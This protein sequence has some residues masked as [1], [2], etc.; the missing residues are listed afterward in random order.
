MRKFLQEEVN[1]ICDE[2]QGT[3]VLEEVISDYREQGEFGFV[4]NKYSKKEEPVIFAKKVGEK[5][6]ENSRYIESY[7]IAT[8]ET[9]NRPIVFLNLKLNEKEKQLF[10]TKKFEEIAKFVMR[11]DYGFSEINKG[12]IAVVEHT[13]ANPIA[14]IHVGNLRNTIQGDTYARI[15]EATGYQVYR[16]FYINDIGLQIG[17][18]V[19][20]YKI[21]KEKRVFPDVKFDHWIGRVY[22][23]MNCL[24]TIITLKR[25]YATNF[26]LSKFNYKFTKKDIDNAKNYF[27]SNIKRLEK[28]I[29]LLDDKNLKVYKK[30]KRELSREI[31]NFNGYKNDFI[32][33]FEISKDL[34]SR[35][36]RLFNTLYNAVQDLDLLGVTSEYLKNYENDL[37]Q[38]IKNI[39]REVTDW[40]IEA[41]KA[42]V[43]NFNVRFDG[44]DYESDVTW[45]GRLEEILARIKKL[46]NAEIQSDGTVKLKYPKEIVNKMC[47]ELDLDKNNFLPKSGIPDLQL[48]RNDGTALYAMKDMAYS[49]KKFEKYKADVVYN[50]ISSE[51]SLPQLQLILPIYQL[52][53]LKVA[54]NLNHYKYE[55]VELLGKTMSGRRAQ[56]ITADDYFFET[57]VRSKIAKQE[58]DKTSKVVKEEK[59]EDIINAVALAS[60]RFPLIESSPNKKITLDLERELDFRRN[61]GPLILYAY[62]RTSGVLRKTNKKEDLDPSRVKFEYLSN[63]EIVVK[64]M[65]TLEVLTEQ[66]LES[67]ISLD[68]SKLSTWCRTLALDFMKFYETEKILGLSDEEEELAKIMLVILIRKGLKTGLN[69]LGLN[70]VEWL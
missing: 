63:I 69:I 66:V 14:P 28:E 58:S 57:V 41:F 67:Q 36:P 48:I 16:L 20:G 54:K 1:R 25:K 46:D 50:V 39:F 19:V 2:L 62:A 37:N 17:F 61:S 15:L 45:E 53:Y 6:V 5:L 59:D 51:Q 30:A 40:T 7:G 29:S 47:K 18:T 64:I 10:Y 23:I 24:F 70:T 27:S 68:P 33:Y 3:V 34:E 49:I 35:F 8:I 31:K 42:T 4:I 56:Y 12:K 52:G 13:S 65:N 26:E 43:N 55:L 11:N 44:F 38:E 22:A 21:L 32:S 9:K 60:T